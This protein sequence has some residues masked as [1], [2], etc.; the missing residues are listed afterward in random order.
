MAVAQR[1]KMTNH[2]HR[3]IEEK[4]R[5]WFIGRTLGADEISVL[6]ISFVILDEPR[7]RWKRAEK[8]NMAGQR[9]TWKGLLGELQ[10]PSGAG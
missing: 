1:I 6:S 2:S 9:P 3:R 4:Q 5:S 10:A 7:P 8:G